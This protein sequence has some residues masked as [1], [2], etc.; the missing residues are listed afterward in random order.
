[1]TL[2]D[3]FLF[4]LAVYILLKTKLSGT[5]YGIISRPLGEIFWG[6]EVHTRVDSNV[7]PSSPLV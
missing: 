6:K 5:I 4:F 1:M 2:K 3:F 7:V